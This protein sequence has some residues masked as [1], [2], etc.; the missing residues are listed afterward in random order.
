M[1]SLTRTQ[2]A[3]LDKL[4]TYLENLPADYK[5]FGM[6][7]YFN[8]GANTESEI[9]EYVTNPN[10]QVH[11]CGTSACA[12]G[13]G[14][15]AGISFHPKDFGAYGEP[16]WDTYSERFCG[17]SDD[18]ETY[19]TWDWLFGSEWSAYDDTHQGAAARIRF[20]LAGNKI[21]NRFKSGRLFEMPDEDWHELTDAYQPYK[22]QPQ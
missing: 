17:I 7:E 21:P 16:N 14:P 12:L 11:E 9:I 10:K 22:V 20:I 18:N 15:A 6:W 4:A 1:T 2:R 5:H 13:H 19:D 8:P 3:N